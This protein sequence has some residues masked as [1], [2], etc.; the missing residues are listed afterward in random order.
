MRQVIPDPTIMDRSRG[1][2][3]PTVRTDIEVAF[4][5][6]REVEAGEHAISSLV[7]LPHWD[8]RRDLLVQQPSKQLARSISGVGCKALRPQAECLFGSID[9]GP[10]CGHL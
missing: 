7:S 5:V 2:Q 6:I 10:G 8:M 3:R 4:G 9:H 1:S